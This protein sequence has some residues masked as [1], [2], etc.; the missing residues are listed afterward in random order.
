SRCD[1]Y[2]LGATLYHLVTGEVPFPG[3]TPVQVA[4]TKIEGTFTSPS[5]L[6]PAVPSRLER[7]IVRM[8]ARDPNDRYQTVPELIADLEATGLN[9]A[10]PSFVNAEQAVRMP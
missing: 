10:A 4:E 9:V 5:K 8:L 6:N 7:I 2:S 3:K 1:I